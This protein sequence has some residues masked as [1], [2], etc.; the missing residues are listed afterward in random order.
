MPCS[1]EEEPS[2]LCFKQDAEYSAE[3]HT[4]AF[5]MEERKE[6]EILGSSAG[7]I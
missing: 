3:S 7:K 6:N 4:G 2:P 5:L 1:S